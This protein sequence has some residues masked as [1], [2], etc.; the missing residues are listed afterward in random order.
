M[1]SFATDRALRCR[2]IGPRRRRTPHRTDRTSAESDDS[3]RD[4]CARQHVAGR[5]LRVVS[6]LTTLCI[7]GDPARLLAFAGALD[8]NRFEHTVLV[9]SDPLDETHMERGSLLAAFRKEGVRVET[10]GEPPRARLRGNGPALVRGFRDACALA[11]IAYRLR[12]Y[13]I[14]RQTD[15]IDARMSYAVLFAAIAGRLAHVPVIVA[16]E[17]GPGFWRG[18]ILNLAGQGA[19][20]LIDALISDSSSKVAEQM[21]WLWRKNLVARA[22]PNGIDTPKATR[23]RAEMERWLGLR[24][25]PRRKIIGQVSRILPSK[26]Y[27]VLIEAALRVVQ[28]EPEVVFLIC[29]YPHAPGYVEEL[30][31]RAEA[32]GIR[33]RVR[34]VSY[35]GPVGDIWSVIDIHVHASLLDSAPIAIHES[36]AL[37]LPSVVT[38]V[39]GIPQQVEAETT[40]LI[41]EAG[42]ASALAAAL[43]RLLRE[44]DLAARMGTAARLRH[45]RLYQP[46]TMTRAIEDLFV[47]LFTASR[48]GDRRSIGAS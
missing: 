32:L 27:G 6:L 25:N 31:A 23:T 8:R 37:G 38:R 44:P 20:S 41:V 30:Y 40:S 10:L 1:R 3:V 26:G 24:H 15:I 36:L 42:D 46:R 11:R 35:P 18:P 34:I 5:K 22:I 13:F 47:E 16:T 19:Y 28:L 29:G 7:G 9:I 48:R 14:D 33:D 21:E 39:G 12:R 4:V 43:L 2:R 17:Y 45:E